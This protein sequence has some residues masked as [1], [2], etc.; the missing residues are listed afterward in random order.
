M[1]KKVQRRSNASRPSASPSVAAPAPPSETGDI[2]PPL[3]LRHKRRSAAR[4][5][6]RQL[7]T[8]V[9]THAIR[10]VAALVATVVVCSVAATWRAAYVRAAV[11]RPFDAPRVVL[12]NASS[13]PVDDPR[14]WGSYRPGVYFGLKTRTAQSPVVGA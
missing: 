2:R 9:T 10:I 6:W 7:R 4:R 5:R 3:P 1:P 8:Y 14:F 13:D 11:R 12:R